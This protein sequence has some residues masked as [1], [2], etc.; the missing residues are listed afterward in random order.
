MKRS[1]DRG[2]AMPM[3][4]AM[5]VI[6]SLTAAIVMNLTFQRYRMSALRSSRGQAIAAGEAGLQYAYWKLQREPGFIDK[7]RDHLTEATQM[8]VISTR[9]VGKTTTQG[10]TVDEEDASL[11]V[12]EKDVVVVIDLKPSVPPPSPPIPRGHPLRIRVFTDYGTVEE[13]F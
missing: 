10:F 13:G 7:V 9:R 5:T 4:I 11:G 2:F 6:V 8:Y 12:G 3:V 1:S